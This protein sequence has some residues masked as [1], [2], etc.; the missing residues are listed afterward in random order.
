MEEYKFTAVEATRHDGFVTASNGLFTACYQGTRVTYSTARYGDSATYM[1]HRALAKLRSGTYDPIRDDLLFKQTWP[2]KE[3]AK[4]LGMTDGQ[5]RQWLV[6]GHLNGQEIIPPKRDTQGRAA[7]RF[8]G[9]EVMA[10]AERIGCM[11]Q[12]ERMFGYT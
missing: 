3:A 6:T 4:L 10:A 9:F 11:A 12:L 5:L 2:I 7:D 8:S 1:A